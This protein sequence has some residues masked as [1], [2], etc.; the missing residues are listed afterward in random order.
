VTEPHLA[1]TAN[2]RVRAAAAL[3]DRRGREATGLTL[4]DGG[5][6]VLRA[7]HAGVQVSEAFVC[8]ALLR[9][10]EARAAV[11][12]IRDRGIQAWTTSEPAFTK[13]AFGDRAEGIVAVIHQPDTDLGSLQLPADPLVVVLEAVEKPG[14]VGAVLRSL[15]GARADALILADPRTDPWNPN[16]IRAS[17]GTVFSMPIAT[18]DTAGVRRFLDDRGIRVLAARTEAATLHWGADLRGPIALVLGS[19]HAGLTDSWLTFETESIRL[20]MLGIADSLNVS[21]AA[22]VLVYEARRQRSQPSQP[23]EA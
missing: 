7:V 9:S 16:A 20:P 17:A 11:A 19:E 23:T 18:A 8:E 3:R 22:A 6:E 14:N 10:D 1:S 15:D 5:R 4:V 12:A 13:I 21:V 2:P